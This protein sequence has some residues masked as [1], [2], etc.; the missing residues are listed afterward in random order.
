[1]TLPSA[2]CT[3]QGRHGRPDETILC[4]GES[5]LI[6]VRQRAAIVSEAGHESFNE[7]QVQPGCTGTKLGCP[8]RSNL[9]PS[10]H[11]A[12]WQQL[13]LGKCCLLQK[14]DHDTPQIPKDTPQRPRCLPG[15]L[16]LPQPPPQP[17]NQG[18]PQPAPQPIHW[19]TWVRWRVERPASAAGTAA[20]SSRADRPRAS[21]TA[22]RESCML[23][24]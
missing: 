16:G 9:H 14:Q 13:T 12:P 20:S 11:P 19:L 21:S 8:S 3:K 24:D 15:S 4:K 18:E 2:V 10:L 1:M 5:T 17:P 7:A 6:P 22:L 23:V